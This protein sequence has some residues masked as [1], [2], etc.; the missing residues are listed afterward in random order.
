MATLLEEEV[1]Y[2]RSKT[3]L[4]IN[5][6]SL[7]NKRQAKR[8]R[9]TTEDSTVVYREGIDFLDTLKQLSTDPA[10]HL[11]SDLIQVKDAS[12]NIAVF[13]TASLSASDKNKVSKGYKQLESMGLIIR[14]KRGMYLINPR[15]SPPYPDYFDKVCLHWVQVTGNQP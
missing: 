7:G 12:S 5:T 1:R 11:I 10:I 13:D 3:R 6:Y 2:W 8:M 14:V 9:Y 15:L 4:P